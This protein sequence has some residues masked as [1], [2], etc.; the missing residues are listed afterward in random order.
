MVYKSHCIITCLNDLFTLTKTIWVC[1]I[2]DVAPSVWSVTELDEE[3]TNQRSSAD[4]VIC[5]TELT[6]PAVM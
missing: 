1:M 5:V 4:I 6:L 3:E 2:G